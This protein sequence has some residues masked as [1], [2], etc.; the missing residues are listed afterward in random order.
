[1]SSSPAN[2]RGPLGERFERQ[3]E[4]ERRRRSEA[5]AYQAQER[6][7]AEVGRIRN[8]VNIR[9]GPADDL[10][11]QTLNMSGRS[12]EPNALRRVNS[13]R[14]G[15]NGTRPSRDEEI[16]ELPATLTPPITPRS[17]HAP[18]EPTLGP[19]DLGADTI[20]QLRLELQMEQ[21]RRAQLERQLEEANRQIRQYVNQ[22]D[23]IAIQQEQ[24]VV[25]DDQ[26]ESARLERQ[27]RGLRQLLQESREEISRLEIELARKDR[28]IADL[29]SELE[30]KAGSIVAEN[31][32]SRN[33]MARTTS[34][35]SSRRPFV[36]YLSRNKASN[37]MCVK[38][39]EKVKK[40]PES[41]RP[42]LS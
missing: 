30:G 41:Q 18:A 35:G 25:D 19:L 40:V 38:K 3:M 27:M 42:W 21:R 13:G 33:R 11:Q 7:E 9:F 17:A 31:R 16:S 32:S 26:T 23:S 15:T 22:R 10:L 34:S 6:I 29:R 8:E 1:M 36:P 4:L 12:E 14:F 5:D 37:E 24:A 39:G 28:M 20:E 2:S